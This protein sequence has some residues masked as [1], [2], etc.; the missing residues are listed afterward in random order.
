MLDKSL[1]SCESVFPFIKSK[2]RE[3]R[4]V[5]LC[6]TEK[7]PARVA[8]T[9]IKLDRIFKPIESGEPARLERSTIAILWALNTVN[10][11]IQVLANR[12]YIS[13][14]TSRNICAC[15]FF[16]APLTVAD[17]DSP[18]S[19]FDVNVF[20]MRELPASDVEN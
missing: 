16:P 9:S 15:I 7:L 12:C 1:I 14:S 3:S 20:C 8:E 2:Q 11:S 4:L 6:F 13:R 10:S 19:S 18:V 17:V 5:V